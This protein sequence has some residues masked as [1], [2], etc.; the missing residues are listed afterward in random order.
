MVA[1]CFFAATVSR[2][3]SHISLLLLV[4][5]ARAGFVVR[6]SGS[7][8]NPRNLL[9]VGMWFY[10]P[11]WLVLPWYSE[12]LLL[13][14]FGYPFSQNIKCVINKINLQSWRDGSAVKR[15]GFT[16]KDLGS[17]PSTYMVVPNCLW[18]QSQRIQCPLLASRGTACTRYKENTTYTLKNKQT[19]THLYHTLHIA[20]GY[21]AFACWASVCIILNLYSSGCFQA[22]VFHV[23]IFCSPWT[24][25]PSPV[26]VP[27]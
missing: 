27:M 15:A 7:I 18:L 10:A 21:G 13:P 11:W 25:K 5:W 14:S 2:L 3:F 4:T 24:H 20:L 19:N 17:I 9:L 8:W 26:L 16:L 22:S 1:R 6:M 23:H 12:D